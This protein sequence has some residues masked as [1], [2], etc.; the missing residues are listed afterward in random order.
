MSK[1]KNE[2]RI[3]SSRLKN[4]DYSTPW[5]YYVT[6]NTYTHKEYFGEIINSKVELNELG[7]ICKNCW[8]E[9]QKHYRNVE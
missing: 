2:Y 9:I 1:F 4:W 8:E 6:I 3:E 7:L 5:W